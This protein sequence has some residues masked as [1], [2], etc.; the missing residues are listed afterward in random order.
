MRLFLLLSTTFLITFCYCVPLNSKG[1]GYKVTQHSR[2]VNPASKLPQVTQPIPQKNGESLPKPQE[3]RNVPKTSIGVPK[4]FQPP[5]GQVQVKTG[6]PTQRGVQDKPKESPEPVRTSPRVPQRQQQTVASSTP[7]PEELTPLPDMKSKVDAPILK[8]GEYDFS[9][10][11]SKA[12]STIFDAVGDYEGELPVLR[13]TPKA[14]VTA[15]RLVFDGQTFWTCQ[16]PSD[17]CL[18][19]ILYFGESGPVAATY[20]VKGRKVFEGYRKFAD[21]KWTS[22]NKEGFNELLE[23]LKKDLGDAPVQ[24]SPQVPQ[25]KPR[26]NV[27]PSP[28][29]AAKVETASEVKQEQR[30]ATNLQGDVKK[31]QD[32]MQAPAS[33]K[34]EAKEEQPL[35]Q[36]TPKSV[37][38]NVEEKAKPAGDGKPLQEVPKDVAGSQGENPEDKST[39]EES[40]QVHT[41]IEESPVTQSAKQR[42]DQSAPVVAGPKNVFSPS[43]V[44]DISALDNERFQSFD[45]FFVGNA[46]NLI[47][48][49]KDI[50]VTRLVD[51]EGDIFILSSGE[52]FQHARVYL[53]K[54]KKPELVLITIRT[55]SSILQK[56]YSRSEAGKWVPSNDKDAKIKNLMVTSEWVPNFEIDLALPSSTDKCTAFEVD[57]LGVT[58]KHFYPR[59][60][61]AVVGV[62]DGNKVLWASNQHTKEDLC[63]YHDYC[64]FCLVYKKENV[65][66][67]EMAV[68]ERN[69][70][71]KKYFEKNADGEWTSIDKKEFDRKLNNLK[72]V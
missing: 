6:Q 31:E 14:G 61:H 64:F 21:G 62:R 46:I 17:A 59:P 29:Q 4:S 22:V 16:G 44:I 37:K 53:N 34:T 2:E 11:K 69:L 33:L 7:K 26:D 5:Q 36:T 72:T 49:K 13:L 39:K 3:K 35:T 32:S 55:S 58:T 47:V 42:T 1:N 20:S 66:L 50:T 27:Q 65:E 71:A 51:G 18:S 12:D 19:A 9:V 23:E 40:P 54:D 25:K 30:P 43:G 60:G 57:L 38:D 70:K 63:G 68:V 28:Q 45:Y 41:T 48:P 24:T 8:V 15:K 10:L 52:T 56:A 67:L